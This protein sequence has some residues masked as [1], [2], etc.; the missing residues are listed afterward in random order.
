[1]I[2]DPPRR[3]ATMMWQF[4]S[5]MSGIALAVMA[6][7]LIA[8]FGLWLGRVEIK[9]VGLGIGGVLFAGLVVGDL[10]N[11]SGLHLEAEVLDFV[12]EF[13][14]I[15]FVYTIG[16]QVGPGFFTALKKS[17][18]RLNLIA[19]S[20]VV[21]GATTAAIIHVFA[22]V[23]LPAILG[24]LSGAVTNTPSLGAA[25][26]VL[27]DLG[28]P[29]DQTGLGYAVAY[30]FGIIG[31]L[32]T[33]IT[34]RRIFRVDPERAAK[35]FE[36]RRRQEVAEI[37]TLD[38]VVDRA[39]LAER[40]ITQLP[41]LD[42]G[43]VVVSRLMRD[44]HLR[45]PHDSTWVELGDVLHLVGPKARLAEVAAAIGTV[46]DAPLTT[47]GTDLTWERIVVTSDHVLGQSIAALNL[48]GRFD[49]RISRVIRSGVELVAPPA[50]KLQFGDILNV[51]GRREDLEKVAGFVGNSEQR[52]KEFDPVPMFIGIAAGIAIGSI[53]LSFGLFGHTPIKLGLAGG[54]LLAAIVLS[55]IGHI[56]RLVWFMPPIAN[57][58]IRELGIVLFLAVV[59]FKSGA[60]FLDTLTHGDG[61]SWVAWGAII[62]IVPLMT[63]AFIAKIVLK[64]DYL[65]LCGLLSGSM[66]D[67]PA[68]AFANAMAPKSEAQSLAY[69]TVYP[70]VMGLRILS[71]QI[72]ALIL[73]GGGLG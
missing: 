63:T 60:R 33:M 65:T 44:G 28:M 9:G 34:V 43:D 46:H 25:Q 30:P 21:F 69:A 24:I 40:T 22:G 56:G 31:I 73:V 50:L 41:G 67:P 64:V 55:R 20:I 29:R 61:L 36:A 57:H 35:E 5:G 54:P 66:T 49:V 17:G 71:P 3:P 59:G 72:L 19:A 10:A 23:P 16:I 32:I 4:V 27:G 38:V 8:T 45:V 2:R 42:R 18:L 7:S 62:T 70:L 39:D 52:L 1:M 26:Q 11:R 51:I 15:L 13:G 12:R 48:E 47:K 37:E 6:L 14:L 58:A 68:L 53:D